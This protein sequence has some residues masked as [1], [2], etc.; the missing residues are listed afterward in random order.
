M[1]T[2]IR[3]GSWLVAVDDERR[4]RVELLAHRQRLGVDLADQLEHH[5][6]ALEEQRVEHLVLG[7]EVVVDE[8]VGDARLVGDVRRRG[9]RGS[10]GARTRARPRRGSGGACRRPS[11]AA[12]CARPARG[13]GAHR[14][15]SACPRARSRSR[16]LLGPAVGARR[17][18]WPATAAARGS[19]CW[20][21]RSSSATIV[22]LAVGRLREHE[23][24]RVDDHRAPAGVLAAG[25]LADLVGGDHERLVLDRARAQ[26]RLPVVA[27]R[28]P[29]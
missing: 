20:R 7:G 28:R 3:S 29:A 15:P 24:P 1:I 17:G 19:R 13:C 6:P 11:P 23:P 2:F 5:V 27:R 18:G 26:Q 25:V 9:R 16:V 12:S 8:A 10:P 14:A 21:S 4:D 22:A